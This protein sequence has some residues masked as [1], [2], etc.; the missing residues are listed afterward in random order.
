MRAALLA[1]LEKLEMTMP[2][3]A[4]PIFRY[5]WLSQLPKDFKGERHVVS[6]KTTPTNSPKIE[7]CEFEERPGPAPP[8]G[9]HSF[10][11]YLTV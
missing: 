1:R 8:R 2:V 11:V 9:E 3:G 7:W 10:T 5:G 6:I 4:P